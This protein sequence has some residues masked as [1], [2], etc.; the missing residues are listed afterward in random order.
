VAR[1]F[2][3]YGPRMSSDDGR[4]MTNFVS[5]AL[6]GRPLT[7][8]G[9]GQQTRSFCFVSDLVAG[10]I[11]LMESGEQGPINLGNPIETTI[12]E[13]A[14]LVAQS[15]NPNT[16]VIFHPLPP[17]DPQRRRPVIDRARKLLHWQPQ[18]PLQQG[19][20][21]TAESLRQQLNAVLFA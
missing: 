21:S 5:Q 17:D 19:L 1:I 15:L 8:Y 12:E 9:D 14:E 10:L 11:A 2:N 6:C 20:A 13:L 18:V 3:T 7:I 4:V 16:E